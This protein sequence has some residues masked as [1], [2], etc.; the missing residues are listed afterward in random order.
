M[1]KKTNSAATPAQNTPNSTAQTNDSTPQTNT[2]N[3]QTNNNSSF[4]PNKPDAKSAAQSCPPVKREGK[5]QIKS[6]SFPF[7]FKPF[8]NAC[9]VTF[10]SVEEMMDEKDVPRGSTF[11]IYQNGEAVLDLPDAFDGQPGCWVEGLA[12]KDL[13]SDGLTDIIMAGGCLGAKDSYPSNAVFVNSGKAFTTNGEANQKLENFKKI[14]EIEAYVK[15]NVK[16][17]F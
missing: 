4:N 15:R 8:A 9:F 10:A 11:H 12:F 5:R 7:N 2:A 14:S 17:F 3:I 13:N 6:Q 1:P 16:S